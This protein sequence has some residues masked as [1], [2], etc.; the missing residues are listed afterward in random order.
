MKYTDKRPRVLKSVAD[1]KLSQKEHVLL[2]KLAL[3]GGIDGSVN[4]L[5][6]IPIIKIP[7]SICGTNLQ[8]RF[9]KKYP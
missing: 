2:T 5:R 7:G 1:E 9:Y 4:F 8:S 6:R 3:L